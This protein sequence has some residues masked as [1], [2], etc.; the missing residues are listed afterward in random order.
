MNT[1]VRKGRAAGDIRPVAFEMGSAPYA[2]GSCIIATGMTRVL[3]T[4]SVEE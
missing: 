3:C 2:E 4:A 1:P